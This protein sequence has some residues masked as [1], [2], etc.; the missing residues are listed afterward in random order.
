MSG[1][2]ALQVRKFIPGIAW[3]LIVL[4]LICLPGDDIPNVNDWF[5][6]LQIDK[7]VH[8]GLFAL[9]AF[10]FMR[11]VSFSQKPRNKKV[12]LFFLIAALTCVWGLATE[13]IQKYLVSGRSFDIF[14][15][16][17]DSAGALAAVLYSKRY[18]L[19]RQPSA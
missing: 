17:A 15:W 4:I 1:S 19:Q 7:L 14:D 13:F 2:G 16:F 5:S 12:A 18:L 9:L 6:R 11:L 10:L 3:F 8:M